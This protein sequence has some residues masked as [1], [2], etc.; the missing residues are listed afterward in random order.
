MSSGLVLTDP[1]KWLT[2]VSWPRVAC[3][4]PSCYFLPTATLSPACCPLNCHATLPRRLVTTVPHASAG[5]SGWLS[6]SVSV[7]FSLGWA[8][9]APLLVEAADCSPRISR[10]PRVGRAVQ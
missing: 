2:T 5:A 3:P 6:A 4:A 7:T 10:D 9:P 8:I 1:G